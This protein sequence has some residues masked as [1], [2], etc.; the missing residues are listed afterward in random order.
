LTA[1]P[2]RPYDLAPSV[3]AWRSMASALQWGCRGRR[4]ESS[5]PD[6]SSGPWT[7]LRKTSRRGRDH[8]AISGD[9]ELRDGRPCI[10]GMRVRATEVLDLLAAG[11][12]GEGGV[13]ELSDLEV[14]DSSAVLKVA[15]KRLDRPHFAARSSGST[16]SYRQLVRAGWRESSG[17][18]PRWESTE[19]PGA[20]C[21]GL[22]LR[23]PLAEDHPPRVGHRSESCGM[24]DGT[25]SR[26]RQEGVSGSLPRPDQGGAEPAARILQSPPR[27]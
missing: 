4:F 16:R 24:S 21:R 13:E 10:G 1:P 8:S 25:G 27:E 17:P 2:A 7:D 14:E 5:R 19:R 9:L 3:G 15:G 18:A 20:Q 23:A 26:R 12:T 11:L 6:H 22:L